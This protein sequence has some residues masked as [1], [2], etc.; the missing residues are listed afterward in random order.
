M[1]LD[2]G[3]TESHCK[4]KNIEHDWFSEI[5]SGIELAVKARDKSGGKPAVRMC[6]LMNEFNSSQTEIDSIVRIAKDI[7]VDSL[8]FS[9]PFAYYNQDFSKVR[10][11]RDNI[12]K[13]F[14]DP[15]FKKVEKYLTHDKSQPFIFWMS[16]DLQD[17]EL[18]DF[19]QCAYGYYQICIGADGY[20]YRCTTVSAPTFAKTHRL[21]ILKNDLSYFQEQIKANQ[22]PVFCAD[23]CFKNGARCNR[24]GLEICRAYRDMINNVSKE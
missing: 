18:F 9:I 13:K 11:Y 5:I 12:E 14:K 3:T 24:M 7:N 4:T 16:P 15:Y 1:S 20:V 8:R 17:I 23:I 10:V 6:Y 19:K 21:G 22:S 2:A